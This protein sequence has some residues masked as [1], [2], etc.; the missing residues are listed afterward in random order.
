VRA[1]AV[2]AE[3]GED[4]ELE[5]EEE[6]E[7]MEK[8]EDGVFEKGTLGGQKTFEMEA[9]AALAWRGGGSV[10]VHAAAAIEDGEENDDEVAVAFGASSTD[11]N[12]NNNKEDAKEAGVNERS[13][14]Q[15]KNGVARCLSIPAVPARCE[16]WG[17]PTTPSPRPY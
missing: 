5:K 3:S 11:T 15:R 10:G 4:G 13:G 12:N 14:C 7:E 17:P 6:E 9:I 2:D 1:A 8:E 16:V